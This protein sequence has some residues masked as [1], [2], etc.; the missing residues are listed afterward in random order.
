MAILHRFYCTANDIEIECYG[1]VKNI[2]HLLFETCTFLSDYYENLSQLIL[3]KK[4]LSHDVTAGSDITPCIKIDKPL[5]VQG[6]IH[7]LWK[8]G[9]DV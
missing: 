6:P 1:N 9:S 4:N 2:I 5:V 7:H 8:G 3:K